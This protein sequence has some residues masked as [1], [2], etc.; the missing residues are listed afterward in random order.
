VNGQRCLSA[1]RNDTHVRAWKV[2]PGM[3]L[4]LL[5]FFVMI[6]LAGIFGWVSDSRD[7]AD[8]RPSEDGRRCPPGRPDRD[9]VI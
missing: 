2:P 3:E 4:F 8:W 1:N 7:S 6:T 5:L 9:R